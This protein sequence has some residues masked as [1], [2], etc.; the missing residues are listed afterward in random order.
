M[1]VKSLFAPLVLSI[2]LLAPAF[3]EPLVIENGKVPKELAAKCKPN[4]VVLDQND[5]AALRL[6]IQL[7]LQKA[8]EE[9]KKAEKNTT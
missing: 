4:C 9:G 6:Q 3:A 5:W 2:S 7:M 8:F 1:L